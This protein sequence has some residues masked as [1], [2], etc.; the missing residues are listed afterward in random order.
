MNQSNLTRTALHYG[1]MSGLAVFLF[2]FLLYASGN[3]IFG[4]ISMLGLWIPVFLL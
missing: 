1:V 4:P 2:N 3:N